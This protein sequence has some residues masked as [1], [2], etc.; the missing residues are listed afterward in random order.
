VSEP[1]GWFGKLAMLGDFAHRRLPVPVVQHCDEWLSQ[2]V[3][4]SRRDLGERWLDA[5]LTA[6]VWCFAWAP[7]VIDEVWWLGV[8]MPSVDAV[9]RYFPLVICRRAIPASLH[10][11]ALSQWG[12]WYTAL[13]GCALATLQSAATIDEFESQLAATVAPQGDLQ[14]APAVESVGGERFIEVRE[15]GCWLAGAPAITLRAGIEALSGYTLWWPTQADDS[16]GARVRIVAGMPGPER[17]AA[18]LQGSL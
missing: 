9:G 3:A 2:G 8:V 15:P 12:S 10:A 13:G 5:Y 4:A 7:R 18:M 14:R 16:G 1:P 17:F 6:P 11:D